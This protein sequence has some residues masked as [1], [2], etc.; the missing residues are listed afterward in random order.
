MLGPGWARSSRN[1]ADDLVYLR[2]NRIRHSAAAAFTEMKVAKAWLKVDR[3]SRT[4]AIRI[5]NRLRF[6][7]QARARQ[8]VRTATGKRRLK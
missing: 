4:T 5:T 3:R 6:R 2:R 7:T 1:S 8:N